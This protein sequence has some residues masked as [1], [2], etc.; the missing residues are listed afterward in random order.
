MEL[1][2]ASG[3]TPVRLASILDEL[4]APV[5]GRFVCVTFDDGYLDNVEHGEPVLRD[6]GIPAT[7]FLPTAMISGRMAYPWYDASPPAL[8]WHDARRVAQRGLIDFQSHTVSHPRLPDLS[9]DQALG[10]FRESKAELER[11]LGSPV[12]CIA[13]PYGAYGPRDVRMVQQMGYRAG[14]TTDPDLNRGGAGLGALCR[15]LVFADDDRTF[16]LEKLIGLHD[17]PRPRAHA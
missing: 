16:F 11:E 1:L 14:V 13:F 2:R 4:A 10:E 9:D 3:A 7:I 15:T 12:T 8:G 6:L 5:R 17:T